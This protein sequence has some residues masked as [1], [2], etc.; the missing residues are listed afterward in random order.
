MLLTTIYRMSC[1]ESPSI[2]QSNHIGNFD[3]IIMTHIYNQK[4][5][6]VSECSTYLSVFLFFL[7]IAS[8]IYTSAS[9]FFQCFLSPYHMAF[10]SGLQ[11]KR[12]VLVTGIPQSRGKQPL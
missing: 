3:K 11:K 10:E 9:N 4:F 6:F 2:F 1:R 12:A 5:T 7:C 8:I